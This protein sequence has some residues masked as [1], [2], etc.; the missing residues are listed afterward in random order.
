MNDTPL[1]TLADIWEIRKIAANYDTDKTDNFIQLAQIQHLRPL[2]G[3]GLYLDLINNATSPNYAKLI[4][5]D[6][7]TDANGETVKNAITINK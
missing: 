6:T 7:Y 5:G 4:D 2:I 1:I 3:A